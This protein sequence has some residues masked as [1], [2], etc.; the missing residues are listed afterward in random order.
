MA[1]SDHVNEFKNLTLRDIRRSREIIQ[2]F[3]DATYGTAENA[4]ESLFRNTNDPDVLKNLDDMN[5]VLKITTMEFNSASSTV[6]VMLIDYGEIITTTVNQLYPM[7][8][9]FCQEPAH[10][11]LCCVHD[12]E[13]A[14][15]IWDL[16]AIVFFNQ[17]CE[18]I[19]A[20]FHCPPKEHVN[21]DAFSIYFPDYHVSL[22]K[23]DC[24]KN[25]DIRLA[26]ISEGMGISSHLPKLPQ[27]LPNVVTNL[28]PEASAS[29]PKESLKESDR[30]QIASNK[31]SKTHE[32][33]EEFQTPE[34]SRG[35]S[36]ALN[37]PVVDSHSSQ[38]SVIELSNST[39]S[40]LKP[41][42]NSALPNS[43][44][45]SFP[46][47]NA[48]EFMSALNTPSP[49]IASQQQNTENQRS[50]RPFQDGNLMN[51]NQTSPSGSADVGQSSSSTD[52]MA[53]IRAVPFSNF[54]A[55]PVTNNMA[56]D[57]DDL[58]FIPHAN[59]AVPIQPYDS[60][61]QSL[62]PS[63]Y[64][65]PFREPSDPQLLNKFLDCVN[66]STSFTQ[67]LSV[68]NSEVDTQ[69]FFTATSQMQSP[70][71]QEFSHGNL[72]PGWESQKTPISLDY[73]FGSILKPRSLPMLGSSK[74]IQ[75]CFSHVISPSHF[76]V[77]LLDEIPSLVR[78]L[79][80]RLNELYKNSEEVPV[81]QPEV[82]SFWVVQ[83]P[84]SQFWSRAKI[85]SVDI[86]DEIGWKTPGKTK[87]P[88]CTVFLVDWGNVDVIPISQLRP[89]VKELLDIPCLALRCR[90]DGIYPFERSLNCEEWSS[91]ATDK[92]MELA[93]IDNELTALV[94]STNLGRNGAI[95]LLLLQD[96][97][98]D[99]YS[100]NE[101]L[102]FLRCASSDVFQQAAA[103]SIHISEES[104]IADEETE[105]G[106]PMVDD[107]YSPMNTPALNTEN[108]DSV[109]TGYIPK[110][111][112]RI[113]RFYAAKGSCYKGIKCDQLHSNPRKNVFTE[114]TIEVYVDVPSLPSLVSGS[115]IHI[116][117]TCVT[118]A[119]RFYAILPH[120]T[121]NLQNLFA[122]DDDGETLETMQQALQEE[123][124]S[125]YFS[126]RMT[127]APSAGD[128][129]IA[130]SPEDNRWYRGRVMEEKENDYFAIY[131]LDYGN[132]QPVHLR[133]L[134]NPVP[135]FIHL[136]AQAV[137]MYLNGIDTSQAAD[138]IQAKNVL[139][140]LVKN[141]DLVA[142]VVH[143]IPFI[144]V[145]L[146]NTSGPAEI[147]IATEMVRRKAT[148]A[149][150]LYHS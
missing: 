18:D 70:N 133:N 58:F 8:P 130:K 21:T 39:N 137:E 94:S 112:E 59:R 132:A 103:L 78:P 20:T 30:N 149:D 27:T 124:S 102:V 42:I 9:K 54:P 28:L 84:Q 85:L 63:P 44:T 111:E 122:D 147:D 38:N 97:N 32:A 56:D 25:A 10:G 110:D 57:V 128:V 6:N 116:Q 104:E 13:P 95:S 127:L 107:Y 73:Q 117:V 98:E 4:V 46:N 134:C 43:R 14:N 1:F 17:S 7:Q 69:S 16:E 5:T 75:C 19:T 51:F 88:T 60:D 83:E 36:S 87:H 136:P 45:S 114:D 90:L 101:Q 121:R 146:Y 142:R 64:D 118:N 119:F 41:R 123:Y 92:F 86:N 31:S 52:Q 49:S 140:S 66:L 113:C 82:G 74:T 143:T 23:R 40:S 72:N 53:K 35:K 99:K 91:H 100:L 139:V 65:G 26:M 55:N 105:W 24:K 48:K 61:Q 144:C 2:E 79:S 62:D 120:G 129:V 141:R 71:H 93:G 106:D 77:H 33:V 50:N 3:L 67:Q 80:E 145:D 29:L 131:F 68:V 150:L 11:L 138:T 89:L 22:Q 126:R 148:T 81:T 96:G 76:Y 109:T 15:Q 37:D 34:S 12:L 125:N 108:Y 115:L 135:R 47:S